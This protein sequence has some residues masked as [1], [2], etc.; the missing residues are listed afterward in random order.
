MDPADGERLR[1]L[2]AEPN[3]RLE[4][5]LGRDFGWDA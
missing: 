5:L 2:F 4:R 1:A 3:A